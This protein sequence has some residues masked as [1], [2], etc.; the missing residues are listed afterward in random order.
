MLFIG[1]WYLKKCN[2]LLIVLNELD[3]INV[4][5]NKSTSEKDLNYE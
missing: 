2:N 1:L 5:N 4:V 3:I